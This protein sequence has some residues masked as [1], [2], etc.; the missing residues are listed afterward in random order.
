[1][2]AAIV[3]GLAA[4]VVVVNL[5][6]KGPQAGHVKDEP[7]LAGRDLQSFPAADEDYFGQMD[8][9]YRGVK[10]SPDE[11]KGRNNWIVW[12]AGNDRLWDELTNSSFGTFD[13]LKTI[14]SYPGLKANRDNRW[15]YLGVVNE[16]CFKKPTAGDADRFGLWLDIRDPDCAPDPFA[17]ADKY[18]GVEIGARGKVIDSASGKVLPVGSFYGEP[19]GIVGLR[20]FP[21]PA[22]DADAAKDWDPERYYKDPA[23]YNRRDLVRP[24][25]V[26]MGCGFCHVGPDPTNPPDDPNNPQFENLSSVVGAQFFWIDRIFSWDADQ[27]NFIFQLV[28]TAKPGTLD[29]SLVSTDYINNPRT[30]NAVYMTRQRVELG[31]RLGQ[32]KLGGGSRD[33]RQFSDFPGYEAFDATYK[34]PDTVFVPH[35]LKDGAD[36]VGVLG[37]LNR[38]YINIGL[39][40]EEWLLHFNPLAGGKP[41]SPIRIVDGRKNSVYWQATEEQTPFVAQFFLNKDVGAPHK[42]AEA[43]DAEQYLTAD[44]TVVTR[45]KEIFAENCAACHSS[46]QPAFPP[47][48]DPRNSAG[49]D[50]MK[51]WDAY[52]AYV[53]TPTYKQAMRE[54]ALQP[55]FLDDNYLSTEMRVPVTLLATNA[56]SPLA[57]NGI[58]GNIWDNFSSQSYKDL[59]SVGTITVKDPFSGAPMDYKM[60]AGGRGYTRPATLASLWS[61]APYLLNN[62]VGPDMPYA[63]PNPTVAYRMEAFDKSIREMLWPELRRKDTVLGDAGVGE[64]YRTTETSYLSIAGGYLPDKLAVLAS[65]LERW[66]PWLFGDGGIRIGPIPKGTPVNILSNLNLRL[67]NAGTAENV[68]NDAKLLKL[69]IEIKKDLKELGGNASDADALKVFANLKEPLLEL[70]KCPDFEV[71]RGHYFGTGQ[72]PTIAGIPGPEGLSDSDKEALI[73]FLKML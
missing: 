30:M 54:I 15:E 46:K 48:A 24:Y 31:L 51:R 61:T 16:P 63:T 32:E 58:A 60:P 22:F 10:L 20:L 8:G 21:N 69:L 18:K 28:H 43:P 1:M 19:T 73:A 6:H 40:S 5:L 67:D 12:T 41:V 57:T 27:K 33:N 2:G 55:D 35:V 65:P 23:Y 59:P 71:N 37:A 50:Y 11:V 53:Q 47:E 9:G 34:A 70:S 45:G 17:N 68:A 7:M 66:L 25:R 49:P 44:E 72:V 13:L 52:W 64:I 62:S 4:V 38:V 29:T 42:L 14:S 56:C 3:I 39:F 36:S 26:G